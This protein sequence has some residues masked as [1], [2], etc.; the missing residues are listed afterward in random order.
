MPR[1]GINWLWHGAVTLSVLAHVA[2]LT[3]AVLHFSSV[4]SGGEGHRLEG[5]E[6]HTISSEAFDSYVRSLNANG[7]STGPTADTDGV[8]R[9]ESALSQ[10]NAVAH[11]AAP[12]A[13]AEILTSTETGDT[14]QTAPPLPIKL[15]EGAATDRSP[16]GNP[17]EAVQPV[18]AD[19]QPAVQPS[20]GATTLSSA[21]AV[22]QP[23]AAS[24]S[25]GEVAR[26]AADVR[27]ALSRSR[28]R[29]AWPSGRLLVA[30]SVTTQGHVID[31]E[32][33][34][35]SGSARLDKLTL[36]WITTAQLPVPPANLTPGDRRYS[37]PLT[38]R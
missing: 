17:P 5:I 12:T 26:Y 29:T 18:S 31:A 27:K 10:S 2:M 19:P 4:Q 28:P 16:I 33:L 13:P 21:T 20:G 34:E 14:V 22:P 1:H 15:A 38:F 30:F 25:P 36:G 35:P 8:A 32:L 37:I 7:G 3:A 24:A 11:K 23:A 9:P 6:V